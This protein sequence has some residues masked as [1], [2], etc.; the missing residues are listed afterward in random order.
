MAVRPGGVED[1]EQRSQRELIRLARQSGIRGAYRM[2]K[3]ELIEA[4]RRAQAIEYADNLKVDGSL[5]D[6]TEEQ[7]E[8]QR[9]RAERQ[10]ARRRA[11]L[12]GVAAVAAVAV[13]V[14]VLVLVLG[15]GSGSDVGATKSAG[16]TTYKLLGVTTQDAIGSLPSHGGTFVVADI[17]LTPPSGVRAFA[18]VAPATLVGGDGVTYEPS[19]EAASALGS[20]SL[21]TKQV[22]PGTPT[23]GKIAFDVPPAAVPGSKLI[24]R[25]L[26]G[27]EQATF[28]TGL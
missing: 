17:E 4:L 9:R 22:K 21:A 6:T 14:V 26:G 24:L 10:R 13:L 27:A 5:A 8:A 3:A 11:A 7:R 19:A 23:A 18:P 1:L 25:D 15:G 2:R 12:I 20:D 16:A 28:K